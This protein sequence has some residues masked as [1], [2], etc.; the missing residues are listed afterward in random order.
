[1][2][3]RLAYGAWLTVVWVALWGELTV[4]NVVG[5]ALV[6]AILLTVFPARGPARGG[7]LRIL[8]TL[9]YLGYFVYKLVEAN[10]IV[11]WEV[12]TPHTRISQGVVE[13]PLRGGSDLVI[14]SVANSI[15][16]TPGTL[17]LEVRREPPTLYVHVLHLRSIEQT[18]REVRHL[19]YLALR[20]WGP[21][22]VV[23]RLR[24]DP[25][26]RRRR[27]REGSR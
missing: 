23:E 22:E 19:E 1:M 21:D 10:L 4:A 16:L 7:T 14:T 6:A 3:R 15:S 24:P 17:T 13:V 8:P 27:D 18:R 20:A 9:H 25:P 11:A 12:V 2:T 26:R 5:G